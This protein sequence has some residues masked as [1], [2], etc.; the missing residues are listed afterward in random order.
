MR[1]KACDKILEDSE[2]LK[3]DFRGDFYDLCRVC[4]NSIYKPELYDDDSL[5]NVPDVLLTTEE[6]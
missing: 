3:K 5:V 4:L 6:F 1:C 2:L